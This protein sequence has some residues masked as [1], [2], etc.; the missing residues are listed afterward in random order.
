[1]VR[2]SS[3]FS[4]MWLTSFCLYVMSIYCPFL[5]Q[6]SDTMLAAMLRPCYGSVPSCV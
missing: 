3:D 5:V 6:H 1:M 2:R 4:L